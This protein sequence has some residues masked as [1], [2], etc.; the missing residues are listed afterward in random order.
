MHSSSVSLSSSYAS[1]W[2]SRLTSRT[3]APFACRSNDR[4]T[5]YPTCNAG[6]CRRGFP[7]ISAGNRQYRQSSSARIRH[8]KRLAA[9]HGY[10]FAANAAHSS[11]SSTAAVV[12]GAELAEHLCFASMSYRLRRLRRPPLI[13]SAKLAVGDAVCLSGKTSLKSMCEFGTA[14]HLQGLRLPFRERHLRRLACV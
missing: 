14:A 12:R 3:A 5:A 10:H 2:F 13:P 11:T 6:G 7:S 1:A 8:P 4:H 9:N